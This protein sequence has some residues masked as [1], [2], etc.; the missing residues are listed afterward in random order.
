MWLASYMCRRLTGSLHPEE[1]AMKSN[2]AR[3]LLL[4]SSIG[5]LSVLEECMKDFWKLTV[6]GL[7]G[8]I[9]LCRHRK[10]MDP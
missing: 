1:F 3:P 7:S 9:Y 2:A 6:K 8:N 5:F 10:E 4:L